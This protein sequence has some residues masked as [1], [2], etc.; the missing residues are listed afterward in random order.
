MAVSIPIA[1]LVLFLASSLVDLT[2]LTAGVSFLLGWLGPAALL[3]RSNEPVVAFGRSLY[4]VALGT[5]LIPV[6]MVVG[7]S[8][9]APSEVGVDFGTLTVVVIVI[10]A[11]ALALGRFVTMQAGRK[12]IS[13]SLGPQADDIE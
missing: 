6:A 13:E 8:A 5:A 9:S 1:P 7:K 3:S 12:P 11:L 4:L 10:A 2:P